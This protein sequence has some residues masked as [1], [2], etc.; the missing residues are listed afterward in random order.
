MHV[1]FAVNAIHAPS[2]EKNQQH[3]DVY[4]S[5][6]CEPETELKTANTNR[7]ELLNE[8]DA[9]SVRAHEPDNEAQGDEPQVGAP[10]QTRN[11]FSR[12]WRYCH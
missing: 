1:M 9:E 4:R 12:Y 2:I 6:L 3:E 7:I 5:L 10:V 8:Q 11:F